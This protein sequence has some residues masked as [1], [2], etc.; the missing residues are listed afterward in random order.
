MIK[1]LNLHD[2]PKCRQLRSEDTYSKNGVYYSTCKVC[3]ENKGVEENYANLSINKKASF[4]GA[5]YTSLNTNTFQMLGKSD[6]QRIERKAAVINAHIF[7]LIK[8]YDEVQ[9]TVETNYR[10]VNMLKRLTNVDV[11]ELTVDKLRPVLNEEFKYNL[12]KNQLENWKYDVQILLSGK[13]E[14]LGEGHV[15]VA[16]PNYNLKTEGVFT[17]KEMRQKF[18]KN[19]PQLMKELL[20]VKGFNCYICKKKLKENNGTIDHVV[21]I[22]LGGTNDV[23]N[24]EFCCHDC[25]QLKSAQ[26]EDEFS[27][28]KTKLD[29]I[30]NLEQNLLAENTNLA[31]TLDYARKQVEYYKV[32]SKSME[33]KLAKNRNKISKYS[34][35]RVAVQSVISME[36]SLGL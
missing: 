16:L 25:N 12:P 15:V 36:K 23:E 34:E 22:S 14:C 32:L 24:L 31:D 4:K 7:K 9:S 26:T 5:V 2:C 28:F 11:S 10:F 3:R 18:E 29:S 17:K 30:G 27:E 1:I 33:A 6:R 13:A 21:P 35:Y 19:K 20:K 8:D